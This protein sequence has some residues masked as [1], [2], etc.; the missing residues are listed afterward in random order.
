[1]GVPVDLRPLAGK[2]E[3]RKGGDIAVKLINKEDCECI[4]SDN[5]ITLKMHSGMS[6]SRDLVI[7]DIPFLNTLFVGLQRG[8]SRLDLLQ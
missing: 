7:G 2:L 8:W 5:M 4:I 3:Y 6:M 1:M